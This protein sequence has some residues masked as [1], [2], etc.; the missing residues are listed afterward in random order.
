MS[1]L[2]PLDP[3]TLERNPTWHRVNDLITAAQRTEQTNAELCARVRNLCDVGTAHAYEIARLQ[4]VVFALMEALV[5]SGIDKVALDARV[6]AA[7]K[8]LEPPSSASA[9]GG[10]GPYR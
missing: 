4:V 7:L 3:W 1:N 9:P 6:A 5:E 10:G 2:K 8:T